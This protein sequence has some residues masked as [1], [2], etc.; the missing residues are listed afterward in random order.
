MKIPSFTRGVRRRTP[1]ALLF[2]VVLA[3]PG[4]LLST[5]ISSAQTAHHGS[6]PKPTIVLVHGAFA[7]A[8]LHHAHAR[9]RPKSGRT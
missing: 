4:V 7:D 8:V 3:L 2:A 5:A 1:L 6:G 9:R